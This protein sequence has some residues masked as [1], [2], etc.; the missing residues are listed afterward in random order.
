VSEHHEL[1]VHGW[2][3][4]CGT[5]GYG[6]GGWG[7]SPALK[8][9]PILTPESTVCHG[10]GVTFTHKVDA[11]Y[12]APQRQRTRQRVAAKSA[13]ANPARGLDREFDDAL[14]RD[15]PE[16]W[17]ARFAD[18]PCEGRLVR[19]HLLPRQLL[20][21]ELP[22]ERSAAAISDPRSW[23]WGCGG[24]SGLGGHHHQLDCS[25]TLRVPWEALPSG[26]LELADEVG[27]T[28]WLIRTYRRDAA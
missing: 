16:C 4:E 15:E 6:R 13:S 23:V 26:L 5:C 7:S 3:T 2:H 10:C 22:A 19:A 27:L 24:I 11:T 12:K 1:V 17:L 14:D 20:L 8:G 18:T 21:R 28:W 9:E 25:R